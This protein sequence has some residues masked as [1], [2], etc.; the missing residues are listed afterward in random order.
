MPMTR[1]CVLCNVSKTG[2]EAEIK[3]PLDS[4]Q[5][6]KFWDNL[7]R[8]DCP[9]RKMS[10]GEQLDYFMEHGSPVSSVEA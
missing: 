10:Q 7:H 1:T 3:D 9:T 4:Q 2:L 5:H 8:A 6:S